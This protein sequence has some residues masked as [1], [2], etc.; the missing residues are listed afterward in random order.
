MSDTFKLSGDRRSHTIADEAARRVVNLGPRQSKMNA[1]QTIS[2]QNNPMGFDQTFD[3]PNG[4]SVQQ[5][6]T[7]RRA[8]ADF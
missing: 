8:A 5:Y 2:F 3:A 6:N 7:M 1:G 4:P